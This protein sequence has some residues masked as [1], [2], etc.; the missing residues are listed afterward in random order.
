MVELLQRQP[1]TQGG[2]WAWRGAVSTS[3]Q[4]FT[5]ARIGRTHV[6]GELSRRKG[7]PVWLDARSCR[8]VHSTA[9][10]QSYPTDVPFPFTK[11]NLAESAVHR[12]C[13]HTTHPSSLCLQTPCTR[14]SSDIHMR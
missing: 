12:H 14:S 5:G 2:G 10:C 9:I 6:D 8:I 4:E 11:T 3:T 7:G 1:Q 13:A